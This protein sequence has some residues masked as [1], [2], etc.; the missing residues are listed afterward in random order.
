[1]PASSRRLRLTGGVR[2]QMW[3]AGLLVLYGPV[4]TT[5]H[6]DERLFFTKHRLARKPVERSADLWLPE[7]R[8]R[9]EAA[10]VAGVG[11]RS[12][13]VSPTMS[14]ATSC[15]RSS[16]IRRNYLPWIPTAACWRATGSRASAM[17]RA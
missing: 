13:P 9:T 15:G 12:L 14:S 1:M 6:L 17:S 11:E 2:P 8:V 4:S 7:Y 5:F 3:I 10:P 16:T